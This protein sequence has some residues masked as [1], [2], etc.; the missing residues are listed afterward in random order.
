MTGEVFT[1]R[2]SI[3]TCST[4]K[5]RKVHLQVLTAALSVLRLFLTL[6][7]THFKRYLLAKGFPH[8]EHVSSS[9]PTLGSPLEGPEIGT[10]ASGRASSSTSVSYP[11]NDWVNCGSL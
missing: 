1:I 2:E 8:S 4:G 9:A 6:D 5:W 11:G 7:P 10:P 3:A